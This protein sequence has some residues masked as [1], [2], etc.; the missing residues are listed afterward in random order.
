MLRWN[1]YMLATRFVPAPRAPFLR[2]RDWEEKELQ[3]QRQQ[4]TA[5][6]AAAAAAVAAPASLTAVAA[7]R[8]PAPALPAPGAAGA[9]TTK[10][11]EEFGPLGHLHAGQGRAQNARLV[12]DL[13]SE[14]LEKY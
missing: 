14:S 1:N 5:A 4:L 10:T 7:D 3:Q 8:P 6:A 13:T 2:A 11:R 12:L 9:R